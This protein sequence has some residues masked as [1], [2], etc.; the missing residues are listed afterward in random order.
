M[1]PQKHTAPVSKRRVMALALSLL[2][3]PCSLSAQQPG[4][5]P[6]KIFIMAG[7]SNMEGYGLISPATTPGTL[8]HTVANDPEGKYQFLLNGTGGWAVRN[9][10]WFRDRAGRTGPLTAGFGSKT[11]KIG[12]ELGFGH[13]MGSLLDE[14]VLIIKTAW[15]GRSLGVSFLPPSSGSTPATAVDGEPGYY[16]QQIL[17]VVNDVTS[18]LGTYF[19]GYSGGGYEFAGFCWHQ[20]WNDRSYPDRSAA[21]ETNM[22]NFI[23]DMRSDLGAPNLPF[24]IA[25]TG[26]DGWNIYTQVESAQLAMT[27]ATTHPAFVGNVAAIDTRGTYNGMTFWQLIKDSPL[28]QNYHWNRNAKTYANIG[29]AMGDAMSLMVRPPR[30]FRLQ[31][32]G[33]ASGVA[34]TWEDGTTVATSVGILRNGAQIAAPPVSP[35]TYLDAAAVPGVHDY[36]LNFTL[37][38]GGTQTLNL[39]FNAGITG[40]EAYRTQDKVKLTWTNNLGYAAIQVRRD[41]VLIEPSLAGSATSYIDNTPPSSG[42]VTYSVVPTNGSAAPTEAS[43]N[44][45]GLSAGNCHIYEPFE[46][47]DALIMDNLPGA[48]LLGRWFGRFL[49]VSPGSMSY[50]A[51]PTS[52]NHFSNADNKGGDHN[53]GAFLRPEFGE[54]GLLDDGTE[55]WFSFLAS[56]FTSANNSEYLTLGTDLSGM[57]SGIADG[58]QGIGVHLRDAAIPQAATWSPNR[59]AGASTGNI[60]SNTTALVVGK[61]TWGADGTSPDTIAIYLPGTDL[62]LP[63]SPV[64]TTSAVLDQSQ[65]D[66]LCI[67]GAGSPMIDE[68][69]FAT[70][71]DDVVALSQIV[72]DT[73]PP[74]PNPMTWASPPASAGAS[75]ITMTATT[76]TDN[77]GVQYYFTETSGNPGGSDSGWQDSPTYT[78][79]GLNPS[80]T[81]SYT[82]KARDKSIHQNETAQSTPAAPATTAPVDITA[83]ATPTFA[84]PPTATSSTEITMTAST[85]TDPS[86]VQYYF[87][88]TTGNPGGSDSGWQ[89]SPIYT[90][91]GLNPSTTYSYT[92][93][94]RDKSAAFNA[95]APSAAL[96]ATTQV[97]ANADPVI[98][99]PFGQTGAGASLTGQAASGIGLTGLWATIGE[100]S[101]KV[102]DGSLSYGGLATSGNFLRNSGRRQGNFAGINSALSNA[103]L[104]ADGG[105]L[106]FSLLHK[107]GSANNT[108][109][110]FGFALGTDA[111]RY[112]NDSQGIPFNGT[113]AG[114]GF[115]IANTDQLTAAIWAPGTA[116]NI[117]AGLAVD[118]APNGTEFGST[119]LIVGK[120]TWGANGSALDK[121]DL[122]LPDT[123]LTEGPVKSSV[124]VT[125]N[126]STLDNI[127]FCGSLTAPADYYNIDE[128]RFGARY[129]DVTPVPVVEVPTI[130]SHVPADGAGNVSPAADLVATFS[131]PIVLTELGTVTIEDTDNGSDTRT[132]NLPDPGVSASGTL[133]T[134]NPATN[135]AFG[136]NYAVRIS[137]DAIEDVDSGAFAGISNTTTW[138]FQVIAAA[139]PPYDN[140]ATGT[141]SFGGDANG[142]GVTDGM[143]WILGAASPSAN[144]HGKLPVPAKDGAF[145]TLNFKRVNA[146]S[147]AKLYV[148]YGN[149]LGGWIG[150]EIPASSSPNIGGGIEVVVVPDLP[151][152]DQV[153]VKLPT[154]LQSP[155]GTLFVR[156]RATSN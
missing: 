33:D 120:I 10:V 1:N 63:A 47:D 56:N 93:K 26:M 35:T 106:W 131:E 75:S 147:P 145:L 101:M 40:L 54:A 79:T 88:E 136:K 149:N 62:V 20:G 154:S 13:V 17:N 125:I 21:Y 142:D 3:L 132:I 69:R 144:A 84:T 76:A 80:T 152:P 129:S 44:L 52:G 46:D 27:N 92:V 66:V 70:T 114:V 72:D 140:W 59:T 11:D 55:L 96:N 53:V 68:I 110:N 128:I 123:S 156:L 135:L 86:G 5:S 16:Y 94:A 121:V 89:D 118:L 8:A 150:H 50:G 45:N 151:N 36:Q 29:L 103:G 71:Y 143:A 127:T 146:Y 32:S 2:A 48:G 19:P 148:E 43:I 119:V 41:G 133:L 18:N 105:V 137:D 139:T 141:E 100:G 81:Y 124:S 58:G 51:L 65:F 108:N 83:P 104:L 67:G 7:Q 109:A 113:G 14:Q 4:T 37:P 107:L 78:D 61:I 12:P 30:P 49:T 95:S 87:A 112:V 130:I 115:R 90:D 97:S 23:N 9:D 85:V 39:T 28:D 111:I 6:V 82:V 153:T 117:N 102:A 122:Y 77:S 25:T 73:T 99:E 22:A 64:S 31:A 155:A 15:G 42:T 34:L 126:Q 24:V 74:A 91:T 57:F 134:I 116:P 60:A 138:N 98:Y 38:G